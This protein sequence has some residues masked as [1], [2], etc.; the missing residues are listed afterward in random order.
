[1]LRP[2]TSPMFLEMT[3]CLWEMELSLSSQVVREFKLGNSGHCLIN[4]H[5]SCALWE[6]IW[7]PPEE[8]WGWSLELH[9]GRQNSEHLQ[10]RE[11]HAPNRSFRHHSFPKRGMHTDLIIIVHFSVCI[12]DHCLGKI[13]VGGSIQGQLIRLLFS[14][15]WKCSDFKFLNH[16]GCVWI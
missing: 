12:L 8:R 13:K 1:M 9:H 11:H 3:S 15:A 10:G 7:A 5:L 16:L 6:E 4:R 2:F 14:K